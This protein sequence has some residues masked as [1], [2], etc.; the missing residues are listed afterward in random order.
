MSIKTNQKKFWAYNDIFDVLGNKLKPTGI[1]VY[2]C[3]I[4]HADRTL[5]IS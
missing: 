4:R 3:L 1:A 5:H 2:L